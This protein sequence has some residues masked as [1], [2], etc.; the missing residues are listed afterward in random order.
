MVVSNS[1]EASSGKN[2]MGMW[3]ISD[4]A[5]RMGLCATLFVLTQ[6][7]T[8]QTYP[9]KRIRLITPVAAGTSTDILARL[10]AQ[11]MTER[12]GHQVIV[13]NRVG[14]G[15]IVGAT[16]GAQA[17]PD[18]YTLTMAPS[19]A[20]A[21]NPA[22]RAT[23]PYD[24]IKDFAPITNLAMTPQTLVA[25]PL[26]DFKLIKELVAAARDKANPINFGTLATGSTS[27]L[28]M[29]LFRSTT[30][31]SVNH[32]PFKGSTEVHTQVIGG[33]IP[34][35]FDAIPAVHPHIKSGRLRGLGIASLKRSPFLPDVPS[36]AESGYPGF[37]AVGWIG[38][39]APAR[40]PNAILD[41]LHAEMMRIL[42][43]PDVKERF[44]TLAFE[45]VGTSRAAF[46][47]YIKAEIAKWS[48][49]VRDSG[50]K[51]D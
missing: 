51:A 37:E 14:A 50:A 36:I 42:N 29:E 33:R 8:A 9:A 24:A 35:L 45:A 5:V 25:Y 6:T 47:A 4:E 12:W 3:M 16:L 41:T 13:D 28:A 22:L 31:I 32:V 7:V 48:K 46:G 39:V 2:A 20:F 43:Q 18:G 10:I 40:T 1:E 19:S 21:I 26:A 11:K 15:S 17:T 23:L 30:G 38:I 27:H 49:V 44:D 34:I